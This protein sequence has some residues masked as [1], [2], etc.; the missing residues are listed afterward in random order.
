LVVED[1]VDSGHTIS[2]LLENLRSRGPKSL[3]IVTLFHK[4]D[5]TVHKLKI[6]YVGFEI[7]SRFVVGYGLDFAEF[8]RELRHIYVL[9]E[10]EP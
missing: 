4:P 3:R 8:G 9:D 1:I 7:P 10:R 6:D 5:A 2:H